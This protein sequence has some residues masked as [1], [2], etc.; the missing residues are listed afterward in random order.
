MPSKVASSN[1]DFERLEELI[2]KV[3]Q[4]VKVLQSNT[5]ELTQKFKKQENQTKKNGQQ[6]RILTGAFAK[7][8]A[9]MLIGAF[10]IGVVNKALFN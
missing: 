3:G 5:D 10:A 8:R 1:K 7:L 4:S 6:T 9:Q 2:K